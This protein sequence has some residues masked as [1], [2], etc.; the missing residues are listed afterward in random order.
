MIERIETLKGEYEVRLQ[1]LRKE[2]RLHKN[3]KVM[4]NYLDGKEAELNKVISDLTRVLK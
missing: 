1:E 4:Y 2:R 3:N